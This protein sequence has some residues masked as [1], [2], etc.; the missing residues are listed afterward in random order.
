MIEEYQK[1]LK[2]L[3]DVQ[4]T[5]KDRLLH[6]IYSCVCIAFG[7]LKF[8]KE[9]PLDDDIKND[10]VKTFNLIYNKHSPVEHI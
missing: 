9:N 4:C 3:A 10:V 1:W 2:Y 8:N 6:P 5:Y 7:E